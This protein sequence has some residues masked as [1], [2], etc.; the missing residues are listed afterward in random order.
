MAGKCDHLEV[1]R[2]L[3]VW[4]VTLRR[5]EAGNSLNSAAVRSVHACLKEAEAEADLRRFVEHGLL[6][7]RRKEEV[8][9]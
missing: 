9:A 2:T 5:P 6:P 4:T 8:A 3:R 1:S 7:G